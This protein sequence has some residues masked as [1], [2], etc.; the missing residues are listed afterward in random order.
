MLDSSYF[1]NNTVVEIPENLLHTAIQVSKT[2]IPLINYTKELIEK[3]K[4]L[5]TTYNFVPA[6][7]ALNYA[8]YMAYSTFYDNQ[9]DPAPAIANTLSYN[10]DLSAYYTSNLFKKV[11]NLLHEV[12]KT[13]ENIQYFIKNLENYTTE[14][15]VEIL[16]DE[17]HSINTYKAYNE[18]I[19]RNPELKELLIETA[20]EMYFTDILE[21]IPI[22]NISKILKSYNV[23]T[24]EFYKNPIITSVNYQHVKDTMSHL[25]LRNNKE[26]ILWFVLN[27]TEH[28]NSY[29]NSK[30]SSILTLDTAG[31]IILLNI[32]KYINNNV[33]YEIE[34]YIG[35]ISYYEKNRDK[36]LPD[37]NRLLE[38][39]FLAPFQRYMWFKLP[40]KEVI[41]W[42]IQHGFILDISNVP[43]DFYDLLKK[44]EFKQLFEV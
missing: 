15:L 44:D 16:E 11:P 39:D 43:C 25:L 19:Y 34:N 31:Q 5:Y 7:I 1:L 21:H 18:I 2:P 35:I 6:I 26:A 12:A 22:P 10:K 36:I 13:P 23:Q 27:K 32:K 42:A 9:Y 3:L 41:E 38:Y 40:Y 24:Y 8:H 37:L 4:I 14:R 29:L 17:K 30:F 28:A 20:L 33:K